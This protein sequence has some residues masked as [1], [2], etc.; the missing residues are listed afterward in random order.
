MTDTNGD[1]NER[2]IIIIIKTEK[3]I[4]SRKWRVSKKWGEMGKNGEK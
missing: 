2:I 3:R 1:G 4:K